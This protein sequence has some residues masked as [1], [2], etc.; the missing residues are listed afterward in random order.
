M[1]T[2]DTTTTKEDFIWS[3][4][5]IFYLLRNW[6]G[7]DQFELFKKIRKTYIDDIINLLK[8]FDKTLSFICQLS[9]I[10]YYIRLL[11]LNKNCVYLRNENVLTGCSNC[12]AAV[13]TAEGSPIKVLD[14]SELNWLLLSSEAIKPITK[15]H[16]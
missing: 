10:A 16:V 7:A 6:I 2:Y 14:T 15:F 3:I 12:V 4:D 11:Q 9:E 5:P 8:N 13:G 1:S